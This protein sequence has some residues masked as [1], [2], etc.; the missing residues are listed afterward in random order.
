MMADNSRSLQIENICRPA[1]FTY[2]KDTPKLTDWIF[3]PEHLKKAEI[4]FVDN[5][6]IEFVTIT[7]NRINSLP[8]L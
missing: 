2:I 5:L 7:N 8:D 1:K 6:N 3:L 4:L